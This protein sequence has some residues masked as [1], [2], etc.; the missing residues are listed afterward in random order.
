M[1]V[2]EKMDYVEFPSA[3]LA[4]TK[5]FFERCFGWNFTD[6]GP[7]YTAFE[8]EGL[9]GGFFRSDAA[10]KTVHGAALVVFYSERLE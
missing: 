6:F 2:H 7:D 9:D 5:D 3:D 4:S 8:N 1:P 10:S